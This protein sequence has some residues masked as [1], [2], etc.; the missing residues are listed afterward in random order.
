M[1]ITNIMKCQLS[2]HHRCQNAVYGIIVAGNVKARAWEE[3]GLHLGLSIVVWSGK[4][5]KIL[6]LH[7][8]SS[9]EL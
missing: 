6:T 7:K 1:K 8:N 5:E 9:G 2:G 3:Q 4:Q